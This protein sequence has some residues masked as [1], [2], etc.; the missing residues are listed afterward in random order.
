M[1]TG[2]LLLSALPYCVIMGVG[3]AVLFGLSSHLFKK[4][5]IYYEIALGTIFAILSIFALMAISAIGKT[6]DEKRFGVYLQMGFLLIIGIFISP[7]AMVPFAIIS[8]VLVIALPNYVPDLFFESISKDIAISHGIATVVFGI[9]ATCL[10]FIKNKISKSIWFLIGVLFVFAIYIIDLFVMLNENRDDIL[11]MYAIWIVSIIIMYAI[12][13]T[14]DNIHRHAIRLR[15]LGEYDEFYIASYGIK[16]KF[17]R[18]VYK[19]KVTKGIL[20]S[21]FIT[22]YD[23]LDSAVSPQ[24]R[25]FIWMT[26]D[27]QIKKRIGEINQNA[28]FFNDNYKTNAVFVPLDMTPEELN[29]V[30]EGNAK[31]SRTEND[32]IQQYAEMLKGITQS[33]E[34]G[35]YKIS[36]KLRAVGSVYGIH[37]NNF[38]LLVE[39]NTFF[40]QN[41]DKLVDK[42]IVYLIDPNEHLQNLYEWRKIKT[43][44]SITGI[45]NSSVLYE[46]I[47]SSA[48]NEIIGHFVNYIVDGDLV[49]PFSNYVDQMEIIGNYGLYSTFFRYLAFKALKE[50]H[51]AASNVKEKNFFVFY[52][53]KFV[54]SDWFSINEFI[55]KIKKTKARKENITLTFDV[56]GE[57]EDFTVLEQNITAMKKM[58]FKIA[59]IN[60]GAREY[61]LG[62]FGRYQAD[63]IFMDQDLTT[64]SANIQK[65]KREII[66]NLINVV[67]SVGAK[68]VAQGVKSYIIYKV[69]KNLGVENFVGDLFGAS[70]Q[71]K[72]ELTHEQE[73]LLTK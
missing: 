8:V 11:V 52:D 62:L 23:V 61:D 50:A 34:I 72:N 55:L 48:T 17:N 14:T 40:I 68:V 51:D 63:Y 25:D 66:S 35:E 19:N 43:L 4:I 70:T 10:Y 49:F 21:Y 33:F 53:S 46:S 7:Y 31:K 22:Q 16:E 6:D 42:N 37:T 67:A 28:F 12:A 58:G 29:V 56:N 69:L 54:S 60:F 3:Y 59:L 24:I 2:T 39:N 20:F 71:I 1:N 32:I 5:H 44:N 64:A 26:I 36:I 30:Y 27:N 38:D 18:F 73:I 9:Y 45:T 41:K 65:E 15:D 57:I 47:Y 13:V